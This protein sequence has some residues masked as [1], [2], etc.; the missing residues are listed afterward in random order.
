MWYL[1]HRSNLIDSDFFHGFTD[2]HSHILPGVDDGVKTMT[3]A[4]GI[5]DYFNRL[6]IS[7]VMLTPHVMNG[8]ENWETVVQVFRMLS[9]QYKGEIALGLGAEYMIDSGFNER[10]DKGLQ[11][12]EKDTVLVETSYFSP[13]N[14]FYESL[15]NISITGNTPIIAH[16]ERYLYMK[17]SDY[18]SLKEKNYLLQLNL[19]SLSGYYGKLAKKN[20]EFL[21]EQGMYDR[22][23]T[24]LHN[25]Q[26]FKKWVKEI[27]VT[28]KQFGNLMAIR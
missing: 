5:L 2:F 28:D 21:L 11:C 6:K 22:V 1:W 26:I 3:E 25:L 24:D 13:P 17:Y 14:N 4:L 10:L 12:L 7:K 8:I 20:A 23:G 18:Y 27:K 16:P 9:Q 19:L 15:Y